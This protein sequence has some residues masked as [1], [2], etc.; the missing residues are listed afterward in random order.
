MYFYVIVLLVI[1][2]SIANCLREHNWLY[3]TG[4]SLGK[5]SFGDVFV[6]EHKIDGSKYAV[7]KLKQRAEHRAEQKVK[8]AELMCPL[9]HEN[10][11][12]Y[13]NAW[14]ER[15]IVHIRMELCHQNLA[16]WIKRRNDLLFGNCDEEEPHDKILQESWISSDSD[17][18]LDPS[19]VDE[20][21]AS[22]SRQTWF[23]G[24][25]AQGTNDFLKGLLKGV[26]YLHDCH[27][28]AHKDLH[29]RNVLLKFGAAQNAVTTKICDFGVASINCDTFCKDMKCVGKIMVWMYY[30]LRAGSL[31]TG[32]LLRNLQQLSGSHTND[33]HGDFHTMWPDQSSWIARLL[34]KHSNE[35]KPSAAEMLDEGMRSISKTFPS[36]KYRKGLERGARC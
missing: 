24:I 2:F 26:R 1:C 27:L 7:K 32:R 10:V 4:D 17:W 18:K 13:Y 5:G 23:K 35:V 21:G 6:V 36:E 15:G 8:E 28:L 30:P 11:C 14:Q 12:R 22:S 9:L 3:R 25:R 19:F 16:T 29:P 33:L 34:S 20:S 31:A